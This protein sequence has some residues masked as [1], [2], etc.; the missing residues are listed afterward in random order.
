MSNA[1][2]LL[3]V[4]LMHV[5]WTKVPGYAYDSEPHHIANCDAGFEVIDVDGR[6]ECTCYSSWTR[7]DEAMLTATYR[8]N[9]KEPRV[10][11]LNY[12]EEFGIPGAIEGMIAAAAG[13]LEDYC[14]VEQRSE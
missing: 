5:L 13:D 2:E 10:F 12:G 11:E 4:W 6:W 8:C 14:S 1:D 7:Q 9:C 3:K